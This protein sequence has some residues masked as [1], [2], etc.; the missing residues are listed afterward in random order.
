MKKMIS[1]LL[2]GMMLFMLAACGSSQEGGGAAKAAE[3]LTDAEIN[4]QKVITSTV[5]AM[6]KALG[7]EGVTMR[8]ER[9]RGEKTTYEVTDKAVIEEVVALLGNLVS[10]KQSASTDAENFDKIVI[11]AGNQSYSITVTDNYLYR[12]SILFELTAGADELHAKL[13]EIAAQ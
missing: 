2:C 12:K 8:Y 9:T 1:I 4:A 11:K 5:E 6:Q 3:D 13:D 10:G 7:E